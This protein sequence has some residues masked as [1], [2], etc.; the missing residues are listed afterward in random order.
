MLKKLLLILLIVSFTAA[1]AIALDSTTLRKIRRAD[2]MEELIDEAEDIERAYAS[3][4]PFD[5]DEAALIAKEFDAYMS[6]ILVRQN[7][8][9]AKKLDALIEKE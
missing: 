6:Y 5:N 8:V 4:D 3:K 7:E 2:T 1:S 9:L